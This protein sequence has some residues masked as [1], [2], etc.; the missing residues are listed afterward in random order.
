M[1]DGSALSADVDLDVFHDLV[2]GLRLERPE[3]GSDLPDR[4]ESAGHISVSLE[5]PFG[6]TGPMLLRFGDIL[7]LLF[8]WSTV[9][10]GMRVSDPDHLLFDYTRVMMGFRLFRAAPKQIE[11][12]GLGGGSLAKACYRSLPDCDITVI[13]IDPEVIALRQQFHIPPDDHRFR[14][15]CADG[16]DY[17]AA[18]AGKPDILF[19]D[20][21]DSEGLPSTLSQQ[22]FY[23]N[24]RA[25]LG[26]DGL[27]VANLCDNS[28]AFA[29]LVRRIAASFD[30]RAIAIPAE[31]RG[32]RVVFA[33][34][35]ASFPP[36]VEIID[37]AA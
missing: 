27:L 20:G 32:N 9:Q 33:S 31:R 34:S 8:G 25:R 21:F 5:A 29:T 26:P 13:E 22:A 7:S 6:P 2:L 11:M 17:L 19:I 28:M 24:C 37:G 35:E 36:S 4:Y 3:P 12:I 15:I 23:D 18:S 30:G 10:S 1:T 14:V 16:A